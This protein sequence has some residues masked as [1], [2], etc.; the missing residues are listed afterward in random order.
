MADVRDISGRGFIYGLATIDL[1]RILC[2]FALDA[3]SPELKAPLNGIW[4]NPT[5][6]ASAGRGS[7][8]VPDSA[9]KPA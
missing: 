7:N 5:G 4:N 6:R 1:H 8:G 9:C 2:N 3:T